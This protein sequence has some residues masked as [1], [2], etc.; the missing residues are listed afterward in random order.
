MLPATLNVNREALHEPTVLER[1]RMNV[2][3]RKKPKLAEFSF[4]V[5]EFKP[6]QT[7]NAQLTSLAGST[8]DDSI[9]SVRRYADQAVSTRELNYTHFVSLS[10]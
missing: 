10:E 4:I 7:M 9:T 3:E 2:K 8:E 1:M 6:T 5:P